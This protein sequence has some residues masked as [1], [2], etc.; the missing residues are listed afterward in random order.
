[1]RMMYFTETDQATEDP[2][3]LNA[4]FEAEYDTA[5][6]EKKISSLLN[7][8]YARLKNE[9]TSSVNTWNEAVA[10]LRKGDHYLLVLLSATAAGP[11][12]PISSWS[13][14]KLLAVAFGLLVVGFIV[15]VAMLHHSD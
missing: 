1:M 11:L 5:E 7:H 12:P 9:N 10:E 15:F 4:A 14:W 13:F 3:E 8:A 2:V 6:Y